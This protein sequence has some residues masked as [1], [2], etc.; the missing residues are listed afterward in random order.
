M[1]Y[2]N[3]PS[4]W[5][6]YGYEEQRDWG[7]GDPSCDG[8]DM[9]EPTPEE[10]PNDREDRPGVAGPGESGTNRYLL[11]PSCR[12]FIEAENEPDRVVTGHIRLPD[13]SCGR[14]GLPLPVGSQ[15]AAV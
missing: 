10:R 2:D 1:D 3:S 15:A 8:P 11:C 5:G 14:C 6:F 9:P 12:E 4:A 13:V 7:V